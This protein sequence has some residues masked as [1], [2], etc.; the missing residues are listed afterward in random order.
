MN[1]R[2][3][4]SKYIFLL[5][6][7]VLSISSVPGLDWRYDT[8]IRI[9]ALGFDFAGVL[10]DLQTDIEVR[11][12]V[13]LEGYRAVTFFHKGYYS[14]W[15]MPLNF[16]WF[17]THF[18]LAIRYGSHYYNNT[19]ATNLRDQFYRFNLSGFWSKA[20]FGLQYD[21]F[22]DDQS[23]DY[24][25]STTARRNE[26]FTFNTITLGYQPVN[27]TGFD[28]RCRLG[29]GYFDSTYSEFIGG[30]LTPTAKIN[31]FIPSCQVGLSYEKAVFEKSSLNF[32]V[33]LGGPA[34]SF[35]VKSLP[36]PFQSTVKR[37]SQSEPSKLDFF[38]NSLST[39]VA[40]AISFQ[41]DASYLVALGVNNLW[42]GV[43]TKQENQTTAWVYILSL[44]LAIEWK[45]NENIAIRGGVR[46]EY[47]YQ[48]SKQQ[49][50][51]TTSYWS[52]F[53]NF[54]LGFRLF[55]D[56]Y[57]D[58]TSLSNL[59]QIESIDLSLRKEWH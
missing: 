13:Y 7:I 38:A 4:L 12:P 30:Q 19:N 43:K 28:F 40:G 46:A 26:N 1:T 44:P 10:Q 23:L 42:T 51:Q 59:L 20:N 35:E 6:G 41:P 2:N 15:S 24:V 31:F 29:L 32:L 9:K 52:R 25:T 16:S 27:L 48:Y 50:S 54:G 47:Y 55:Q 33:D 39:R 21:F 37:N 22:I 3:L 17:D 11:N 45:P 14:S 58:L 5:L 8:S 34:S 18:G 49:L 56:W 53:Q 36:V 57:L